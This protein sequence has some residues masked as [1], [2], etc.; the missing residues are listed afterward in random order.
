[1][2]KLKRSVFC[3][4]LACVPTL[5]FAFFCPTNFNQ[6]DFG[7]TPDQVTQQCGKP[8][9]VVESKKENQNIPQSWDF[10]IKAPV[11]TGGAYIDSGTAGTMKTSF[12]FNANGEVINMSVDGIGVGATSICSNT[13]IQIGATRDQV[14]AACG[15]P[16]FVTKSTPAPG[17][18]VPK[19]FKIV[20]FEYSSATP[21]VT[22]VF[23]DGVLKSKK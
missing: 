4:T 11:S 16:G 7:M 14:K 2:S 12:V 10:Y 20:E 8:T 19:D 21:P 17:E 23:E 18:A 13:P 22:L 6:I 1:M 3:C 15:T 9:N 5:S